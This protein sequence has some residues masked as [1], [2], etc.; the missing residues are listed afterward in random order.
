MKRI[1]FFLL[2]LALVQI[3]T[4]G[5]VTKRAKT[6]KKVAVIEKP[7]EIP[8]P[9]RS[10]DC[11]FP[12]KLPLD[13]A[14]GPT[15]PLQGFG[16]VNEIHRDAQTKNVFEQ[17]HNTVW[18][19]IDIPYKG[20][21]L[22]D[23]T[24][25]GESNDYDFLV[26]K[27]TDKYFCNRVEKNRVKPIRSIMS[28][29]NTNNKG[30]TGLSL[31]GTAANLYKNTTEGYGRYIDV[32]PGESY[33]IVVDNL[34]DGGLGHTIRAEV[35]TDYA[36]LYIQPIDSVNKQRTTANIHIKEVETDREVL[37]AVDVGN[38]RVKLLPNNSYDITITKSGY[39]NYYRHIT[40]QAAATTK[41]SI[42]T[43]RLV[44][45]KVGSSIPMKGDLAFDQ[46]EQ[47]N[48]VLLKDSYSVLDDIVKTL[49]DY[50]QI[51]I[52]VIGRIATEGL[53]LRSD[54]EISK[55]RAD[56]IKDYLV[57][58]GIPESNITTRGSSIKELEKQIAAQNKT[59]GKVFFPSCEIKI[60]SSR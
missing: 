12:V 2:A 58:K 48:T 28:A 53:N 30:T 25:K 1:L 56:A 11:F 26:Y 44:E 37:N 18:Y 52:E 39:F 17:E 31:K 43:A 55:K 19:Q 21:L 13:S 16:F 49:T 42:I 57:S 15:E 36:P 41:D 59:R 8:L 32:L 7:A 24:P 46:D 5:Q 34:T 35:Y 29:L 27:Y 14:F 4:F 3:S 33:V 54:N 45:I 20:K 23:I 22:I 38:T 6:K 51:K 60:K 47:G 50:P 10:A 40:Y 9:P